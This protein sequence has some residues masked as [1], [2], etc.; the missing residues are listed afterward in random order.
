MWDEKDEVR[1]WAKRREV[2]KQLKEV[3]RGIL[4]LLDAGNVSEAK[5]LIKVILEEN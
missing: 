4:V 5:R 3:L 2:R 1:E